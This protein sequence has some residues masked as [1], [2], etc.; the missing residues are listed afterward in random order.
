[1]TSLDGSLSFIDD[2]HISGIC[3]LFSEESQSSL[4]NGTDLNA[5]RS[6]GKK[7]KFRKDEI[8]FLKGEPGDYFF[9]IMS[10]KVRVISQS[11]EGKE[12]ILAVLG[13][14]DMFGEMALID[15]SARCATVIAQSNLEALALSQVQFTGL[16]RHQPS[17]FIKI[18]RLFISRIRSSNTQIELLALRTLKE[19]MAS[20][21]LSWLKDKNGEK[22]F[23]LPYTHQDISSILGTSRECV[24]RTLGE[25]TEDGYIYFRRNTIVIKNIG[26]LLKLAS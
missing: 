12:V 3:G 15:G 10:G 4:F 20:L 25:L 2:S 23:K 21:L 7:K 5:M 24:T 22:C 14:N 16:I 18:I 26:G 9:I 17:F 6:Y 8:I 19:R 13:D 1:M 11:S